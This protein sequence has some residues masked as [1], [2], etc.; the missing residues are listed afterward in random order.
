MYI[1]LEDKSQIELFNTMTLKTIKTWPLSPGEGPSGLAIDLKNNILFSGC[2]NKLMVVV[3]AETGKI[4]T[5][6]PIGGHVDGCAFDPGTNLAFSSN[7]EGSLTI[8][9]EVSPKEFKVVDNFA[10]EK[11]LRTMA[12]DPATNKIYLPG[13][14]EGKNNEKSFG[15]LILVKE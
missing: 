13:M 3:N 10:T 4:I 12:L 11:G 2:H 15:V 9:K 6:L 14:L 8:I 1:N 7:G 5:T